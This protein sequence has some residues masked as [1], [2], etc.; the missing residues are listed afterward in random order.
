MKRQRSPWD[1]PS[2]HPIE[3][4]GIA[5]V[6]IFFAVAIVGALRLIVGSLG[7]GVWLYFK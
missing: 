3:W 4:A 5:A 7:A 6:A 2:F 1:A